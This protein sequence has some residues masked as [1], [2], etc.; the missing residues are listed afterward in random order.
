MVKYENYWGFPGGSFDEGD[1]N[2][3]TTAIREF[4]E[5]T[6]YMGDIKVVKKP[7]LIEKSNHIDFYA[8]LFIVDE[9]F[10]PNLKGEMEVGNESENYAWF[11][12][13]VISK[14]MMPTVIEI[15]TK[16]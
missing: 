6:G 7:I 1:G 5:E 3:K 2:S 9:E 12:L 11:E 4:R 14:K 13:N 8:Y 15:L 10:E 16:K